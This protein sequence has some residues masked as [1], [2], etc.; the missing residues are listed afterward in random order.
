MMTL[1]LSGITGLFLTMLAISIIPGPSDAAVVGRSISGG[2]RQAAWVVAGI[3]AA[4]LLLILA[5]A[6]GLAYLSQSLQGLFVLTQLFC[7]LFFLWLAYRLWQ[8]PTADIHTEDH[9]AAVRSAG[10]GGGLLITL[11]D[12]KALLFYMGLLPAFVELPEI[13]HLDIAMILALATVIIATVKLGY[14]A[15]ALR[16]S[17]WLQEPRARRRFNRIGS[18]VLG[19][20]AAGLISRNLLAGL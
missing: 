8:A 11:A 2:F 10:F 4:D 17:R 15:L 20:I 18:L 3:V 9:G 7:A 5:A 1:S 13:T 19:L 14:A 16:A 6:Y 12:P